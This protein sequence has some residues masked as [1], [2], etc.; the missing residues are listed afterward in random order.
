MVGE[1]EH[2]TGE[3]WRSR[4]VFHPSQLEPD[5]NAEE[6]IPS[7]MNPVGETGPDKGREMP[8]VTHRTRTWV[9]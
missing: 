4:Q 1:A 6:R 5:C 9:S 8:E 7:S 3:A 2:Q